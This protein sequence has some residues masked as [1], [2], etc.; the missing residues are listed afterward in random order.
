MPS[1]GNCHANQKN[2][3]FNEENMTSPESCRA[4]YCVFAV[5]LG[6]EAEVTL[7]VQV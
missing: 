6:L 3:D 4:V 7:C 5:R 2:V 1:V